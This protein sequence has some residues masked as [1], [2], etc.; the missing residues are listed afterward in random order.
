MIWIERPVG[1]GRQERKKGVSLRMECLEHGWITLGGRS[2][3]RRDWRM[4]SFSNWLGSFSG[5]TRHTCSPACSYLFM[6]VR[7]TTF[8]DILGIGKSDREK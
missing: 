5:V 2:L 3:L 6:G 8:E 4:G 7:M 1:E